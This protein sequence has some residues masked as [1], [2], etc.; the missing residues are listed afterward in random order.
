[1]LGFAGSV[2]GLGLAYGALRVLVAIAP[3]GLPRINEIGIDFPVLLFTLGLALV[4]SLLIGLVP[5]LRYAGTGV[6]AT[7]AREGVRRA[8]AVNGTVR[9]RRWWWCRL[10]WRW[11]C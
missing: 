2:I 1:M 6:N 3:E 5:V 8:R 10:R 9:A 11:C 7:F 4:V